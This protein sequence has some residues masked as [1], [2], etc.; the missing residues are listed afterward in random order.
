MELVQHLAN[1][2]A[3]K[4]FPRETTLMIDN[5]KRLFIDFKGMYDKC[6]EQ[7]T[8][9]TKLKNELCEF[10]DKFLIMPFSPDNK[11]FRDGVL[12]TITDFIELLEYRENNSDN[13]K[14]TELE[15]KLFANLE[16]INDQIYEII[17]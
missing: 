13:V 15:N 5:C 12:F 2:F 16:I 4:T 10:Y 17:V 6:L 11:Q 7:E 1:N 14:I 3:I 8:G 9:Y